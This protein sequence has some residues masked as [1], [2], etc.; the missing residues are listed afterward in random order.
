MKSTHEGIIPI[1]GLPISA[2][3]CHLFEEL[4]KTS[5]LS[6]GILV[7]H[8]CKIHLEEDSAIVTL[9]DYVILEGT[10]SAQTKAF[11]S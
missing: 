7:D 2:C 6:M 10:R 8:G 9:D 11:G 4:G 5:L 3:K 1:P